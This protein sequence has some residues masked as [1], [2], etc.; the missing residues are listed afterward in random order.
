MVRSTPTK[1]ERGRLGIATSLD[2][3][4]SKSDEHQPV[5]MPD[6]IRRVNMTTMDGPRRPSA[7]PPT[8]WVLSRDVEKGQTAP[9]VYRSKSMGYL[10]H[11]FRGIES[12]CRLVSFSRPRTECRSAPQKQATIYYP[13]TGCSRRWPIVW[14]PGKKRTIRDIQHAP[15]G[16]DSPSPI[17]TDHWPIGGIGRIGRFRRQSRMRRLHSQTIDRESASD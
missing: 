17:V 14:A 11:C 13:T 15:D 7:V 1:S 3:R 12:P 10:G 16:H 9:E 8:D 2:V 5:N 4:P 6:D